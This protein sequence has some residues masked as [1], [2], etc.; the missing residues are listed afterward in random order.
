MQLL[1]GVTEEGVVTCRTPMTI[2]LTVVIRGKTQ[3]TRESR[4]EDDQ[5]PSLIPGGAT[6]THSFLV[7]NTYVKRPECSTLVVR[8]RDKGLAETLTERQR[9]NNRNKWQ[10]IPWFR[11]AR[12]AAVADTRRRALY[13]WDHEAVG[14]ADVC[15]LP[16]FGTSL[17]DA[18]FI[19]VPF[20]QQ[21]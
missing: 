2:V 21:S 1:A 20:S 18:A 9:R 14:P 11:C 17:T 5:N 10:A 15:R 8:Q 6:V 7:A 4:E 13:S 16:K 3:S 19:T 12:P